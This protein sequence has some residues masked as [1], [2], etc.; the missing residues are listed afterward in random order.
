MNPGDSTCPSAHQPHP[1]LFTAFYQ[2]EILLIEYF[3][4]RHPSYTDARS[5]PQRPQA[6][7]Q[8]CDV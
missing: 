6:V 7:E 3:I 5:L 4:Y 1:A 2:S 8:A